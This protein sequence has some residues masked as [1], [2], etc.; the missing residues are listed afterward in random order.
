MIRHDVGLAITI[1]IAGAPSCVSNPSDAP[2]A[3]R[4]SIASRLKASLVVVEYHLR[5]DA[6]SA[7]QRG[8]VSRPEQLLDLADER[9]LRVPGFV[10]GERTVVTRDLELDPRF[11]ERIDV[12]RDGR[13]VPAR[14][15][16]VAE[17][18]AATYLAL[19]ED[20][21][22]ARPIAF[23]ADR[24]PALELTVRDDGFGG[25]GIA[26]SRFDGGVI[27]DPHG[28]ESVATTPDSLLLDASGVPLALALSDSLHLE[29]IGSPPAA[30]PVVAESELDRRTAA[31][32]ASAGRSLL[33]VHFTLR[34]MSVRRAGSL[35]FH[36]FE[37][38]V[39][40]EFHAA[41]GIVL[42]D[43]LVVVLA[44]L[45]ADQIE[46]LETIVVAP[47]GGPPTEARFVGSLPAYGA[48]VV[49]P[50]TPIDF[51]L[52]PSIVPLH[53][54]LGAA[55]VRVE[56]RPSLDSFAVDLAHGRIAGI[57]PGWRDTQEPAFAESPIVGGKGPG[58]VADRFLFDSVGRLV[59][60]ELA[61]R[62]FG[63]PRLDGLF[64]TRRAR[65]SGAEILRAATADPQH[66]D[67]VNVPKPRGDGRPSGWLGVEFVAAEGVEWT[68]PSV[69]YRNEATRCALVTRVHPG[70]PAATAGVLRGDELLAVE[71]E[72]RSRTIIFDLTKDD[73]IEPPAAFYE[74]LDEHF[75]VASAALIEKPWDA[76]RRVTGQLASVPPGQI[77]E[78][79]LRREGE[80][81]R[82]PITFGAA[83][84]GYETAPRFESQFY[85][86]AV[87]ELTP[88]VRH[89][90][91]MGSDEP[92]LIVTDVEPKG[93]AHRAGIGVLEL[94][95]AGDGRALHTAS[96]FAA[97]CLGRHRLVLEVRRDAARRTVEIEGDR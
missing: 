55:L 39:P 76:R 67:L 30:W 50:A 9:P 8:A 42:R 48:Y 24:E 22:G 73:P 1:L 83:P 2:I 35:S 68:S 16:S 65:V 87:R 20:L 92:G 71:L 10:I 3:T 90:L 91:G 93:R 25:I 60:V 40:Q 18:D 53:E 94:L 88:E 95:V 63:D 37:K 12:R 72:R 70:S 45:L 85:G 75:A 27:L 54:L 23:V 19:E 61:R 86:L 11:I 26:I 34:E 7:L 28:R 33:A 31:V 41:T 77:A 64:G 74:R 62:P 82:I 80:L 78:L 43:D 57:A 96:D 4:S 21:P 89:Y 32:A 51:G 66:F 13:I 49:Q 44:D 56:V 29:R 84:P 36:D 46:R 69:P 59:A 47:A 79:H 6:G 5:I 97:A 58:S 81:L 17:H 15:E 52:D 14:R 38:T